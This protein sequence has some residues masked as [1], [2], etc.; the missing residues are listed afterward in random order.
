MQVGVNIACFDSAGRV[1]LTQREDFEVW[2]LPGGGVDEGEGLAAAALR[3]MEEETGLIVRLITLVGVYSYVPISGDMLHLHCFRAVPTGGKL[4]PEPHEV[5]ALS[6]FFPDE[7]PQDLLVG[8]R[9]R[10]RDAAAGI[11]GRVQYEERIYHLPVGMTR[12]QVYALRDASGLTRRDFYRQYYPEPS[13]DAVRV[14][15]PGITLPV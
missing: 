10:I 3:E 1:L 11:I 2:C 13:A 8:Q 4:R 12:A 14:I 7:L 15:V 9:G 5:L 6:W